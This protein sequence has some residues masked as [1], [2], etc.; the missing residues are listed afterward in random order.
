[1]ERRLK[2]ANTN[3]NKIK[4]SDVGS[5]G[6]EELAQA[7][8]DSTVSWALLRFEIGSG[9]FAMVKNVAIICHG[10]TTPAVRRGRLVGREQ[11]VLQLLGNTH[12]QITVNSGSDL[13]AESVCEQVKKAFP[14]DHFA[15]SSIDNMKAMYKRSKTALLLKRQATLAKV[16]VGDDDDGVDAQ[17]EAAAAHAAALDAAS[18][19]A[20]ARAKQDAE[21]VEALAREREA[22][23]AAAAA[24]MAAATE[25][26]AQEE[27]E[28]LQRVPLA[29]PT[30]E[31][32]PSVA[33][34]WGQFNWAIVDPSQPKESWN[35]GDGGLEEVL[36]WLDPAK[37][38]FCIIRFQ[39]PMKGHVPIIK[40]I[41]IHWV[42]PDVGPLKRGQW[43]SRSEP[44][45]MTI[46]K[47]FAITLDKKA[48]AKDDLSVPTLIDELAPKCGDMK[49]TLEW[50]FRGL[51]SEASW[52]KKRKSQATSKVVFDVAD[53]EDQDGACRLDD[54]GVDNSGANN[55]DEDGSGCSGQ[56]DDNDGDG[57]DDLFKHILSVKMDMPS[58]ED[59]IRIVSA[60]GGKWNWALLVIGS[61]L[62][63]ID[64]DVG[65][66]AAPASGNARVGVV[67]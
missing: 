58:A 36:T 10:I 19:E 3:V 6:V 62:S 49:I 17:A 59:A 60:P 32:L 29:L 37:V 26:T 47:Y 28:R 4:V 11:E 22:A 13:S 33:V 25:A 57:D 39:F 55:P 54:S 35:A 9:R 31:V 40:H 46:S 38:Q 7:I 27:A 45:Q 8:D 44:T 14:G 30:E 12:L 42:G 50:Y 5:G 52:R 16:S 43:N 34:A 1:M 15:G 67:S 20:E 41:F 56:S 2:K 53:D 18:L 65:I 24:A 48:Y 51:E 63:D 64:D 66:G 23:E 61:S 21:A